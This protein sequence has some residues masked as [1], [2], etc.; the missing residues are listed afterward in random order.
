[1]TAPVRIG[2]IG[3]GAVITHGHI[4][5]FQSAPG[6]TINAI[7]DTNLD[8]ARATADQFGIPNAYG[9]YEELLKHGEI[10][11]VSIGV[12]NAF[13]AP[14][15]MAAIAAG[16]HVLCEK[17][18]ATSLADG[19]AMVAAAERAGVILAVNMS[20]RPRTEVKMLRTAV[21]DGKFGQIRYA[22]GR[23]LR[24]TG[25]PGYGS[26]FTRREMSGGGALMDIGVHMIDMVMWILGFPEVVAVR[27]ETQAVHGPQQR[28]LGSWGMDHIP[29]GK[30]DV[31][32]FAA[33]HLRLANGGLVTIEVSWAIYARNEER[34]QIIG[35]QGGADFF[36]D[37]YGADKPMRLYRDE[38][39]VPI[40]I[41]PTIPKTNGPGAWA[42]GLHCFVDAVRGK[43]EPM[44]TGH[45]G[46]AILRLLDAT[47]RS[48]SEGH[49]V[50]L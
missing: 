39:G 45:D 38:D 49:E 12:P 28:G 5:G 7:C 9:S 34:F 15:A 46:L 27:G 32:D 8:R 31:D 21:A 1:M 42:Q 22:Y 11:A 19:E 40:E 10:D 13:H 16:K 26:W 41:I 23:L 37:M 35:D 50:R 33:M 14:A 44:A 17:P 4:P 20:N 18:L 48:A 25:I 2:L 36:P 24:R 6:T 3:A 30:F 47:N 43:G 29:G